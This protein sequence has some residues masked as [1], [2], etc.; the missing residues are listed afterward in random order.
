VAG[1]KQATGDEATL[2]VLKKVSP[3]AWR[4]VN[5]TGAFDFTGTPSSIDLDALM[6]R[7]SDPELWKRSL[8]EQDVEGLEL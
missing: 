3:V 2:T 5:L 4:H 7:Y 6:T 8:Q 1:Q